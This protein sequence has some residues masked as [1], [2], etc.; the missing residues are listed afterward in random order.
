MN[1]PLSVTASGT[2]DVVIPLAAEPSSVQA[3]KAAPLLTTITK[4][5]LGPLVLSVCTAVTK[6]MR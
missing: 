6:L 5:A 2:L 4:S 1:S 3:P